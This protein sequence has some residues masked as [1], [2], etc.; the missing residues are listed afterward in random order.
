MSSLSKSLGVRSARS[1][2]DWNNAPPNAAEVL[3]IA[4]LRT[5]LAA[6][7][8]P[9][10]TASAPPFVENTSDWKLLRF[11]R[12][13]GDE[14]EAAYRTALAFRAETNAD[15]AR[16]ALATANWPWPSSLSQFAP[17][18]GMIGRGLRVCP[19]SQIGRTTE[20]I[21]TACDVGFHDLKA[22]AA[23]GL[24]EMYLEHS[25]WCD[26]WMNHHLHEESV[27]LG[28]LCGR[29]D[30]IDVSN[31]GPFQFTGAALTLTSTFTA[32]T[33]NY[34]EC[35]ARIT[36]CGNGAILIVVFSF[37]PL[38]TGFIRRYLLLSRSHLLSLLREQGR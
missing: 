2:L 18:I 26:E 12:G 29:H 30:V 31:V 35:V 22:V 37:V 25:M 36:S 15:A 3:L 11:V 8:A 21:I 5:S 38:S 23:A 7:L 33:K 27:R 1:A 6:E 28:F 34:P 9:S 4:T 24:G 14:A 20:Y 19:I 10:T 16:T 17:L 13:H 32:R